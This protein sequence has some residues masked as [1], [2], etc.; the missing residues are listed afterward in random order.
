[1]QMVILCG[2]LATRLG[3][4][5]KNIP[6]S[7]IPI[8]GKPFLKYQIENLKKHSI[9]DIILC[10]SHLSGKI[11]DYFGNGEQFG[12]NIKYSDDGEKPLG[13]IGAVKNAESLLEDVFFVMYGDSYL[14]VD[15]QKVYSYFTQ[16]NKLGLMVVYKNYD[17]YDKSNL[18][19][20]NGMVV[21]HRDNDK[22]KDIEYIDYGTSI[23][24]KNAL[25]FVPKNT[26]YSTKQFFSDLIKKEEL[27]AFEA[28]ERFYHIGNPDAIEEFRS[29]I[30]SQ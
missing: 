11:K 16:N 18:A 17:K 20:E 5:A 14:S 10:V 2:G 23:F 25:E 7:M 27:L 19:V 9:K 24:R 29:F 15:F 13:P 21:G 30:R 3:D 1:M 8:E 28:K 12:A 4:L 22:T 6:K 26:F